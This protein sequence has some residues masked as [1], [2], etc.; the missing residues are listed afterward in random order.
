MIKTRHA[1]EFQITGRAFLGGW[2]V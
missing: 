1:V 2:F